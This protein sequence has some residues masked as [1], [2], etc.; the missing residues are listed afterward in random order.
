MRHPGWQMKLLITIK[1]FTNSFGNKK[2]ACPVSTLVF[3]KMCL[4]C[5]TFF[6][7]IRFFYN[8]FKSNTAR[9]FRIF[10]LIFPSF[11]LGKPRN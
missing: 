3:L 2:P 9:S 6:E 1:S 4:A 5:D 7:V 10:F 11:L 8:N